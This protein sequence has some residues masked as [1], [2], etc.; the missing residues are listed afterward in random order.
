MGYQRL[1]TIGEACRA[2]LRETLRD[3]LTWAMQHVL[4]DGWE[5]PEVLIGLNLA[6]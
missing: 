4:D 6:G 1:T 5:P 2:V 3:T